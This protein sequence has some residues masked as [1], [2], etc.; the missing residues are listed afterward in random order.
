MSTAY[1]TL[2]DTATGQS[3]PLGASVLANG[4]NFSVY[5]RSAS[6]VEL[7]LF[8]RDD[9]GQPSRVIPI[10]PIIIGTRSCLDFSE[11]NSTDIVFMGRTILRTASGLIRRRFYS[12]HTVAA[13]QFQQAIPATR[14]NCRVTTHRSR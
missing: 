11:A 4:V 10:D 1:A 7:L 12:T 6:A 8:D 13:S 5:S 3:S 2:A 9:D 14:R